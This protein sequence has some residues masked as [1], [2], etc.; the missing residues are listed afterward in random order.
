MPR[1]DRPRTPAGRSSRDAGRTLRARCAALGSALG[2]LWAIAPPWVRHPFRWQRTPVPWPAVLRGALGAGPLLGVS[3]ATG[4]GGAGVMAGVG[5]MLAGVNDRPGTRRTGIAHIGVPAFAGATGVLVGSVFSLLV[6]SA[7]WAVPLLFAVGLVS[8]AVS[9]TGP[10]LSAAAMQLL[11]MMTVSAGM[12]LPGTPWFKAGCFLGGAAWLLLLRLALRPLR[13]RGGPLDGERAAVAQVYDALADALEAVGRPGAVGARRR[14]TAALDRADE[15]LAMRRFLHP[16]RR[17]DRHGAV[18][19]ERLATAAALCEAAV[20]LLCEGRQLPARLARGPR[21]LAEAVR[22]GEPPGALPAPASTTPASSSFDR[23]LLEAARTFARTAPAEPGKPHTVPA[24]PLEAAGPPT[25]PQPRRSGRRRGVFGP[26]GREYGLQVAVC[27]ATGAAVAQPLSTEHWYWIPMTAA[28]LAK[29]DLGPLFSRTV[30][31]FA[32]TVLGVLCFGLLTV[33]C[34]GPWWPV[35]VAVATGALIP[36][37]TRH[38]ALQTFVITVL[39]LSFVF[40]AG[41][42]QAAGARLTHT[43]VACGIVLIAGH[44]TLALAPGARVRHRFAGAVRT[45]EEYVRCALA[46]R[47]PAPAP[48]AGAP[49]TA[50]TPPSTGDAQRRALRRAAYRALGEARVL[51]DTAA[52]EFPSL[53]GRANEL[54]PALAAAESVVDSAT[55]CSVRIANGAA[56]PA[57]EQAAR[58]AA[59]LAD[60]AHRL[61][62]HGPRRDSGP[63][64]Q[65]SLTAL[66]ARLRATSPAGDRPR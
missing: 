8:G 38:F 43:A 55:A 4:H 52:A 56:P 19:G 41:D 31:R 63:R 51:A 16:R 1:T 21:R 49:V 18:L 44:L 3:V 60:V 59:E 30:N 14:L 2:T 66:D 34:S 53:R 48:A 22:T 62:T 45:T 33:V 57:P 17:S 37:A 61:E 12:P 46:A 23:A 26:A 15:A 35:A 27:V 39:V 11:V 42:T 6:P 20:A 7:W 10:V 28:F 40:T 58:L 36:V 29:P 47:T 50:G 65:K 13:R 24:E 32:G 9:V 64:L 5:A 54:L 25:G